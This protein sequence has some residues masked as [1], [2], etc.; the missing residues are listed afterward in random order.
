[1]NITNNIL[2]ECLK[3][4]YFINGTAY[5]GK[6]TMVRML[7][8]KH[9]MIF[10]GENYHDDLA[11]RAATPEHQPG[12]CYFRT[13]KSWQE[14]INRTPEE[15]QRWIDDT[16]VEAGELE[17]A[18]LLRLSAY[19]KKIIADTNLSVDILREIS[20]YHRVALMLSPQSMSV[21]RFFEREDVD[22]Q[23]ILRQIQAAENPQ[24]T[25]ENYRAC[26]ARINRPEVYQQFESSGFFLIKREDTARDT[27]QEVLAALEAH[28]GL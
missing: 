14:F 26:I 13:M 9:D 23:F 6:S 16:A 25:M 7:A 28:F 3:N 1:M 10:C 21:D 17:V 19:G 5:A 22:K 18:E 2:K 20:D 11:V 15:Y 24:K 12:L 8:Q 4:V 27:R